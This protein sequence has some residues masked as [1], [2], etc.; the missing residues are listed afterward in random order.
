MLPVYIL[1]RTSRRP[2]F[3][4][5]CMESIQSQTYKNII[6]IVHTDDPRD[7]YVTGDIIIKGCKLTRSYG[8]G[9]YNIY[10]NRLLKAIPS[11]VPGW[12]HCIDDDDMYSS[13]DVIERLVFNAKKDH[14]NIGRVIRWNGEIFP[15]S[16]G[17]QKSY[18]TECFFM[19]SDYAKRA[20][21]PAN[22]GGDHY[23]SKQLTKV[24]PINWIENLI[25]CQAQEGK[26]HGWKLDAGGVSIQSSNFKTNEK[27]CV[28]GIIPYKKGLT[29][30]DW[31]MQNELKFIPYDQAVELEKSGHVLI[32]YHSEQIEKKAPLNIYQM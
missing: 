31:I 22:T 10:N 27:I 11:D 16:W 7:E 8:N 6:T 17:T 19:Y 15:K 26:G 32:T 9:T 4:K 1:I 29:K 23:Y 3:F 13:N 28:I 18:Q 24:M 14:V 20:K 5:K 25:I 12:C 2:V 30:R 21:W